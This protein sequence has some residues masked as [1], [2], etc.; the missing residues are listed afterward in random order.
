[1]PTSNYAAKVTIGGA[2]NSSFSSAFGGAS[3]A[4]NRLGKEVKELAAKRSLLKSFG[5]S[6]LKVDKLKNSLGQA[7]QK[8][9][10]TKAAFAGA[11]KP[12]TAFARA[13]NVADAQVKKLDASLK[14][15]ITTLGQLEAKMKSARLGSSN[16]EGQRAKLGSSIASKT[17]RAN[18]YGEA[19]SNFADARGRLGSAVGA[20][21]A[22]GGLAAAFIP[23]VKAAGEFETK[24]FQIKRTGELTEL[25]TKA[26]ADA[27]S[28][29]ANRNVTNRGQTQLLASAGELVAM[30][31]PV[32]TI[33]E[34]IKSIG[35]ASVATGVN[36]SDLTKVAFTFQQQMGIL[37]KDS[38][39]AFGIIAT[40]SKKG[41]FEIED[42]AKALPS[43]LS[44]AGN[45]GLKG[46]EGLASS[47]AALEIARKGAGDNSSA[48]NN[49]DNL[50]A[51][52]TAPGTVKKFAENFNV[53]WTKEFEDAKK[54][55]LDPLIF[56][57]D[58]IQQVT[59]GNSFKLGKLFEDMQVKDA[60]V[61][62]LKFRKE[63]DLI[64]SQS[65]SGSTVIGKD[66]TDSLTT[67][68]ELIATFSNA[69]EKLN[70]Q[71]GK[72][73][74][75]GVTILIVGLSSVV[76][77]IQNWQKE[78]PKLFSG[79]VQGTAAVVGIAL[80]VTSLGLAAATVSFALTGLQAIL[81]GLGITS[82]TA[83]APFAIAGAAIGSVALVIRKYWEPISVF[84]QGVWSGIVEG[85]NSAG[86]PALFA[87][88]KTGFNDAKNSFL[89]FLAP[90]KLSPATLSAVLAAGKSLG[91]FLGVTL[92]GLL[93]I[94]LHPIDNLK[95][96]VDFLGST[97]LNV[98]TTIQSV[99]ET[100]LTFIANRLGEVAGMIS[101]TI[102]SLGALSSAAPSGAISGGAGG[103]TIGLKE[104]DHA[105]STPST[106]PPG[107][108]SMNI[109]KMR[110]VASNGPINI[111]VNGAPGQSE[112]GI[113][114]AV[115]RRIKAAQESSNRGALYD[116]ALV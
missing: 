79:I 9:A 48:A 87:Q 72:E 59:G 60:L 80:A 92:V 1:M 113:A 54:K 49:V 91:N 77:G 95:A 29:A 67:W 10:A 96:A 18:R 88:L 57:L 69:I 83:I 98:F 11:D 15:E 94:V 111:N 17:G 24:L 115:M 43:V 12:T 33:G 74:I 93:G 102:S 45:V 99:A 66:F 82:L 28:N 14:R 101:A 75:G 46:K 100:A 8:L 85:W 47:V 35:R 86:G 44:K 41:Q 7:Q 22:A 42:M 37:G 40:G 16:I 71:I 76:E 78:N 109:P 103:R 63:F 27:V 73:L 3:K 23:A 25:Q 51:K 19:K 64:R 70:T 61:P 114:Q 58:R 116:A 97:F 32:E 112:E 20:T 110:G 2:L 52:L 105:L 34:S 5:D 89:E 104:V 107:A 31:A 30:G 56:S 4:I 65:L 108:T 26:V 21:L 38:E 6:S 68:P 39:A 36:M 106:A 13:V 81:A 90:I 84:F 62:L 55:G 50:F 53:N